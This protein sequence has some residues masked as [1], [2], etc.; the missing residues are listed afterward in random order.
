M[1]EITDIQLLEKMWNEWM[2]FKKEQIDDAI[3]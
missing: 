2:S 1:Y 3:R